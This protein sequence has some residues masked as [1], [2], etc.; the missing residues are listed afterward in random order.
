[1]LLVCNAQYIN[2]NLKFLNT[3]KPT[4]EH[5]ILISKAIQN[6]TQDKTSVYTSLKLRGDTQSARVAVQLRKKK[7]TKSVGQV[8]PY[9]LINIWPSFSQIT[10]KIFIF[11]VPVNELNSAYSKINCVHL[12]KTVLK[13]TYN[14]LSLN[15]SP[16]ENWRTNNSNP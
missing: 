15:N 12:Y 11:L 2:C 13:D 8:Y 3:Q 14:F 5:S 1:M 16:L 4:F 10:L 7:K 6:C 9:S